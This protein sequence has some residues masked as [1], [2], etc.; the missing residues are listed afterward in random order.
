[1]WT[2][3]QRK[4]FL[5]FMLRRCTKSQLRFVGLWFRDITPVEHLDFTTVLPKPVSLYIFSLLD[6]RTLCRVAQVSWHWK[7]LSEQ[8]RVWMPKCVRFGWYLPYAPSDREYGAWKTHYVQCIKT[9]DMESPKKAVSENNLLVRF[10][11]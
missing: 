8:D 10:M 1:M 4:R 3:R 2:D 5:Q 7:L 11:H 6:P 9:L